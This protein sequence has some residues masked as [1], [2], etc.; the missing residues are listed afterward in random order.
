MR[1]QKISLSTEVRAA[2]LRGM[3]SLTCQ[4]STFCPLTENAQNLETIVVG[5]TINFRL[6][7]QTTVKPRFNELYITKSSV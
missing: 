3:L 7:F 6:L 2:G 5:I 1:L 4:Y